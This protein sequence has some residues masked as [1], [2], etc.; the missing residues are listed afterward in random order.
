MVEGE[1]GVLWIAQW[2]K[3]CVLGGQLEPEPELELEL[4][5][6]AISWKTMRW[7]VIVTVR[8]KFRSVQFPPKVDALPTGFERATGDSERNSIEVRARSWTSWS[9]V[10]KLIRPAWVRDCFGRQLN[11]AQGMRADTAVDDID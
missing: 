1:D 8:F 10:S 5:L 2:C 4:A 11:G 9:V 6:C 7:V 3:K